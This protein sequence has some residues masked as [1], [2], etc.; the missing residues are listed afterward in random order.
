[1]ALLA[2]AMASAAAA[3][4]L[5]V[6]VSIPPQKF[7][8]Q[9]V[10]GDLVDVSVMVPPGANPA[11]FEPRPRQMAA[12]S[13]ARLYFAAGVPFEHAWLDR[14][15]SAAPGL[16]IVHTDRG[17]QKIPLPKNPLEQGGHSHEGVLDPHVWT[18][19]LLAAQMA[20]NMADA[21]AT[22]D[23]GNKD[24]Y[25]ENFRRL[26]RELR[27]LDAYLRGLFSGLSGGRFLVFHP[28]WG[29]LAKAY[30]LVQVPVEIQGKEPKPCQ[31]AEIIAFARRE[32][33]RVIFVQ[34]Q[35]SQKSAQTLARSIDGRVVVADPL[36]ED[37]IH[38]LRRV[39]QKFAQAL[40]PEG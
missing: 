2:L 16:E 32:G 36:A 28:S 17:I 29:Y 1:M 20:G 31:L 10:G 22:A 35:F 18:D 33:I 19:P 34:P 40:S 24:V 7:L 8:A 39:G 11:T 21:L 27:E 25:R 13:S 6:F 23:P 15:A 3:G 9:R 14:F 30:G 38:N 12:L 26:S 4:P 5:G 37:H